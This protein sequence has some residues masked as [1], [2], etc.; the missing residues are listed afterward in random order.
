MA[1]PFVSRSQA[2]EIIKIGLADPLTG[3]GAWKERIGRLRICHRADK[4]Q[5]RHSRPQ[6]GVGGGGLEQRRCEHCRAEGAQADRWRQGRF[7]A[8]QRQFGAHARN[9]AG[10]ERKED[11]SRRSGRAC[12][13][14]HRIVLPLEC[15]PR[16]Q[17]D[18]D[19]GL[20][21]R[22][23]HHQKLWQELVL[24]HAG[25]RVRTHAR[26]RHNEGRRCVGGI[27]RRRGPDAARHD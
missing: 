17:S 4:R 9:G 25:L 3:P 19:I 27:A 13:R 26:S 1:S 5:G 7:S 11:S 22:A 2:G 15:L 20:R 21:C 23:R 6:S 18:A 24:H 12:R 8:R 10:V 14:H 16:L